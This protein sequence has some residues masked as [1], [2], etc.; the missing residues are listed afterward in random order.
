M[1]VQIF[2]YW[3]EYEEEVSVFVIWDN[4]SSSILDIIFMW[5][6]VCF[7]VLKAALQ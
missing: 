1:F 3:V 4:I 2:K 5:S 7:L 6:N